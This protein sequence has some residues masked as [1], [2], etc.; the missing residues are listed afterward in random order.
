MISILNDSKTQDIN[1][2][3]PYSPKTP[4]KDDCERISFK[5]SDNSSVED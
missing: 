3:L 2:L 1:S 5:K 4:G